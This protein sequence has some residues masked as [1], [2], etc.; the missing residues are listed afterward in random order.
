M[1]ELNIIA[2]YIPSSNLTAQ[3]IPVNFNAPPVL[4]SKT[5]TAN[6][7]YEAS[8][9]NATGYS[10]VTVAVPDRPTHNGELNVTPTTEAQTID[11]PSYLDGYGP[12]NVAAVTSTIDSNIQ[13]SNIKEGVS[14]LGVSGSVVESNETTLNVT[15]TT[16]AQTLSPTSPY[17]GFDEVNVSA[18]TSSIDVNIQPENIVQGV[19]ILGTE[20]SVYVPTKY[21]EFA[22]SGT[23]LYRVA[24][25]IDLTGVESLADYALYGVYTKC[26]FPANTVV[27]MRP[28]TSI[29]KYSCAYCFSGASA[30]KLDFSSVTYVGFYGCFCMCIHESFRATNIKEI[31][32]SGLERAG[33][34]YTAQQFVSFCQGCKGLEYVNFGSLKVVGCSTRGSNSQCFSNAFQKS[35]LQRINLG[36]LEVAQGNNAFNYC[37]DQCKKL[38]ALD[39]SSLVYINGDNAM[40]HLCAQCVV[41]SSPLLTSLKVVTGTNA[42]VYAFSQTNITEIR[43]PAFREATSSAF[44]LMLSQV[45]DVTLHF[46]AN[47]QNIVTNL[48]GYSATTPFGATSGT[49]LFDLPSS[50]MLTGANEVVYERNPKYD[51][52]TALAWRVQDTGDLPTITIDWTPFYTSGTTDPQVGDTLYSDAACTTAVTTINT[53]A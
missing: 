32:F 51:T 49:V 26:S 18:V 27:D 25:Q 7:L 14:I 40:H 46:P 23:Q 37:F 34:E 43:F 6:G 17:T 44:V 39:L 16:S 41:M 15:P 19:S 42:L 8:A 9:D 50:Y 33:Y 3:F 48:T 36:K 2:E 10:S 38:E 11:V 31:D 35:E 20:G 13:P 52:Q 29:N 21:I 12:V 47:T 53:I 4:A 24:K 30:Q 22:K 5:I 45:P 1:P 28:V